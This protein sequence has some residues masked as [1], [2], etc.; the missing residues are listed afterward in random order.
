[1][2]W[3][4]IREKNSATHSKEIRVFLIH[5]FPHRLVASRVSSLDEK[6]TLLDIKKLFDFIVTEE[7]TRPPEVQ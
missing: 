2:I 5:Y 4:E 6:A 7:E 3:F 1:M